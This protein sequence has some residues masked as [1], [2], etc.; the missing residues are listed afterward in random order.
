MDI[1]LQVC[2]NVLTNEL[3][4]FFDGDA[5]LSSSDGLYISQLSRF[6][7]ACSNVDD[8]NNRNKV[9]TS[10]LLKQGYQYHK[11]RKA[12]AFLNFI[13]KIQS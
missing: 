3:F 11:P 7:R 4:P 2:T 8:F 6:A 12:Y 13:T 9:L 1:K 5:S 10:K